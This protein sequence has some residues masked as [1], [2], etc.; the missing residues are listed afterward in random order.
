MELINQSYSEYS[1]ASIEN[2]D[3]VISTNANSMLQ[4]EQ[5]HNVVLPPEEQ[6]IAISAR[7]IKKMKDECSDAKKQTFPYAELW[8]GLATLFLGAFLSALI[9]QIN[10]E[11][12]FLSVLFYSICPVGGVGFGVSYF[13][14]RKNNM[15][16]IADFAKR[17]DEQLPV[18]QEEEK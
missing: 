2:T 16:S 6:M 10:Y 18:Y 5:K 7:T 8:L 13:F 12:K 17:I 14:C 4:Y 11:L 9:S 15:V 3:N 1:N